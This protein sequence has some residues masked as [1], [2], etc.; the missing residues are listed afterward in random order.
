MHGEKH[1]MQSGVNLVHPEAGSPCLASRLQ[2]S[3]AAGQRQRDVPLGD[4]EER[5][6]R[7]ENRLHCQV[8]GGCAQM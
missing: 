1:P 6:E 8:M 4:E 3:H 2:E 5:K 7:E